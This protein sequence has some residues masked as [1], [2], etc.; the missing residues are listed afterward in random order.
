[1]D[2]AVFII[3]FCTFPYLFD[4]K[5][6]SVASPVIQAN[7]RLKVE[8][9]LRSGCL[10]CFI[11]INASVRTELANSMVIPGEPGGD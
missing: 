4:R 9:D 11:S 8:D 7:G 1:M 10:L 6:G 2:L 3:Q 5:L